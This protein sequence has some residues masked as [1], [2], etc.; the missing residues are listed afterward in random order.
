[1]QRPINQTFVDVGY[2][3]QIDHRQLAR[4]VHGLEL[5]RKPR[6]SDQESFSVK[7]TSGLGKQARNG[8]NDCFD[9]YVVDFRVAD[10]SLVHV[11]H[12]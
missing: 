9:T 3:S 7:I 1:V 12:V 4:A 10:R 6:L 5:D 2:I 8:A 11:N